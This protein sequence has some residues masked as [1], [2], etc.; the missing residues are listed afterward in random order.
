MIGGVTALAGVAAIVVS[1][2]LCVPVVTIL[3]LHTHNIYIYAPILS[4]SVSAS[5]GIA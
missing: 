3:V 4:S 5:S 1:M 2:G